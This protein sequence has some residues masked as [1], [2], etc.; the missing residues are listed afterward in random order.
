M[1]AKAILEKIESDARAQAAA[2]LKEAGEKAADMRRRAQERIDLANEKNRQR[3]EL[4]GKENE[5]RM[6]RM[7]ELEE[8]K[9]ELA[10]KREVLDTVFSAAVEALRKLD[11]EKARAFFLEKALPLADGADELMPG[12]LS[13]ELIDASFAEELN[14]RLAAAGKPAVRLSGETVP[15]TGLVIRKGGA[16]LNC[17]FEALVSSLRADCETAVA[18]ILFE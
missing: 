9:A 11:K 13:R 4:D 1:D 5:Q 16:Q 17:T 2:Y 15:G 18:G 7:A 6:L 12:N 8:K 14:R 10:A 3:I